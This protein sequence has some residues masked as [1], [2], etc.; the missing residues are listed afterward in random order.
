M[1]QPAA[2]FNPCRAVGGAVSGT[3]G[4]AVFEKCRFFA[5]AIA[6]RGLKP[7]ANSQSRL[8]P[9]DQTHFSS[10]RFNG[11]SLLD[12]GFNPCRA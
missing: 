12:R 1:A 7:P 5:S 8:K 6:R 9:T 10:V 2:G 11:L 4:G 3:M